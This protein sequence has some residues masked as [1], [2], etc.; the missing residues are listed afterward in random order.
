MIITNVFLSDFGEA[1]MTPCIKYVQFYQEYAVQIRYIFRT[2][3]N[4]QYKQVGHQAL[5]YGDTAK[6]FAMNESLL[7]A[8]RAILAKP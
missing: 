2:S 7:F 4:V 5:V 3:E 1:T 6:Y 8:N